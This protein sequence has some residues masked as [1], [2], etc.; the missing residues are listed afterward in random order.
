MASKVKREA[1]REAERVRKLA[2]PGQPPIDPAEVAQTLGLRVVTADLDSDVMGAL[3]KRPGE[4]PT[5]MINQADPDNR[6]RF[7][8]AHEL[9]H[10]VRRSGEPEE[11]ATIDLR[12]EESSTGKDPEEVF[13]NE[14]AA[15]LLIPAEELRIAKLLGRSGRLLAVYFG[16]SQDAM[17][18]R[19]AN[20][21]MPG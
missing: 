12:S 15:C 4:Q 17:A 13:A 20:L 2:W 19:L 7:T 3:I 6:Q 8:C 9:G 1:A 21:G 10:W 11:F 18:Y 5:I 16:V 14:F